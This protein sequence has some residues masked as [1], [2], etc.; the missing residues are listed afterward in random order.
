MVYTPDTTA[1]LLD[2]KINGQTVPG[3]ASDVYSYLMDLEE[4]DKL[5]VEAVSNQRVRIRIDGEYVMEDAGAAELEVSGISGGSHD[6]CVVAVAEDGIVKHAYRV[7][8]VI[9]YE[10]NVELFAFDVDGKSLLGQFDESGAVTTFV[11][12]NSAELR[13]V[14]KDSGASIQVG[15]EEAVGSYR[16]TVELVNGAANVNVTITARDG[17]TTERYTVNL[18]KV[19]DPNDPSRDIP[20]EVLTATAGDWQTGYEA[21]EGPAELV[22]DGDPHTAELQRH[23]QLLVCSH[24]CIV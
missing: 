8:A 17:V 15:Q 23:E 21:T 16:G 1:E 2:L 14:T 11:N 19:M 22:L 10:Q 6:I 24:G 7:D 9:P 18:K 12:G 20:V 5:K 13:I 4:T 3:F